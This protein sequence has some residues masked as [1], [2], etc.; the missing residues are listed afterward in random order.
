LIDSDPS[1]YTLPL[2]IPTTLH[3][4]CNSS[5]GDTPIADADWDAS[6]HAR[7]NSAHKHQNKIGNTLEKI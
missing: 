3:Q 7:V 2:L 6:S 5:G 4:S 1:P